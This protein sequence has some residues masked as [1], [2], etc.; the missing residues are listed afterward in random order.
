MSHLSFPFPRIVG[1]NLVCSRDSFSNALWQ[2]SSRPSNLRWKRREDRERER[3]RQ[4]QR[5]R[6]CGLPYSLPEHR[7]PSP[8]F[9]SPKARSRQ[10]SRTGAIRKHLIYLYIL[11]QSTGSPLL[12][13]AP[14]PLASLPGADFAYSVFT[15]LFASLPPTFDPCTSL[16]ST[17]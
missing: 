13:P 8:S 11:R 1:S 10:A 15:T 9:I 6:R 16:D 2:T 12:P 5:Q 7:F 3:K 4:R 14:P 17:L